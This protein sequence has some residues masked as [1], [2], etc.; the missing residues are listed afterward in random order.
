MMA[1]ETIT[2]SIA[3]YEY[4]LNRD[5][6]LTH[7]ESEGVD[8]WSGYSRLSNEGGEYDWL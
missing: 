1:N 3:E 6:Q 8:N 5:A 7:L 4:L 2:I